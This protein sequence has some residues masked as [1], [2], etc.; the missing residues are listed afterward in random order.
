MKLIIAYIKPHRLEDVTLALREI[1]N[2]SGVSVS[3]VRG[4]GRG[5]TRS[6]PDRV[7]A[8][9]VDYLPRVRLEIACADG[10]V[11]A[12]SGAIQSHAHTGLRGDGKIYVTNIEHATR[13]STAETGEAAV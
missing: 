9:V 11:E 2:L 8:G 13:I 3:D 6:A 7:R 1:T 5:R 12:V 10:L 4:F